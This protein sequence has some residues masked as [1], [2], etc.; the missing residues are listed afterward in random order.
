MF[1]FG[2]IT[3]ACNDTSIQSIPTRV[4]RTQMTNEPEKMRRH[5]DCQLGYHRRGFFNSCFVPRIANNVL[6]F[7]TQ[8]NQLKTKL[9]FPIPRLFPGKTGGFLFHLSKTSVRRPMPACLAHDATILG[10][11]RKWQ[12]KENIHFLTFQYALIC[13]GERNWLINITP[14]GWRAAAGKCTRANASL[15]NGGVDI[16]N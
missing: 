10:S 1:L 2:F 16:L 3:L 11:H 12:A 9:I 13:D 7:G 15:I 14:Q 8:S 5:P 4:S 6:P